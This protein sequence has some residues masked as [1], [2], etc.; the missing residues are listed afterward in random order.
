MLSL[1]RGYSSTMQAPLLEFG[2]LSD[3]MP[4]L[5]SL[6]FV[7]TNEPCLDRLVK[8]FV[9]VNEPTPGLADAVP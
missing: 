7:L 3:P 9:E 5:C 1:N 4:I 8:N 2:V 6:L